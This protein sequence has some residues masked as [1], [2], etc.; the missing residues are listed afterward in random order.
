MTITVIG[1]GH[2]GTRVIAHTL[3]AS[4][5]YMGA[6][7]NGAGDLLPPEEMYEACRVLARRVRY[8]GDLRWDFSRLHEGSIDPAFTRLIESYLSSV[9]SSQEERRGWKIPETTLVYPWVVRLFPEV[10]Y[11]LWTR[12]PR[13]SILGLHLTDDLRRFGIDY[14]AVEDEL[15]RRAISYRYQ[16]ALVESTPPP[17]YSIHVRFEDVV[18]RQEQTLA[19]IEAF[20]GFPLARIPVNPEAVGRWRATGENIPFEFLREDL[21]RDGYLK[22]G[23]PEEGVSE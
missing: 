14:P 5:V 10:R 7:L 1:R 11:I 9:L 4:G 21:E 22:D 17:R 23:Y 6:E 12:D 18:L 2:G 13:D 15:E 20:L 3:A 19:R 8:L 16:R